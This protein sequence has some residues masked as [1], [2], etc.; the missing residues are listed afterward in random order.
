MKLGELVATCGAVREVRSRKQKTARLAVCLQAMDD[1]ERPVGACFLAGQLPAGRIG[2]GHAAVR[3]AHS[4]APA[5]EPTLEIAD[6]DRALGE[7]AALGGRGSASS[8]E[9]VLGA[10]FSRASAEEQSF[11]A[12]L[13]IGELRQGASEGVVIDAIAVAANVP[14]AAVRR[15][16]MLSGDLGEVARAALSGGSAALSA[17][18]LRLFRPVLPMLAQPIDDI[19]AALG[20]LGEASFELKLDGARIQLHKAEQ[21]IRVFSRGLNDVTHAVPELVEAALRWPASEIILD[22]EVIALRE[23]GTPYPFQETMRRFGR[24]LDVDALRG[25]RPLSP[26]YFDLLHLDGETLVD[27]PTRERI[28][29]LDELLPAP[30]RIPRAITADPERVEELWRSAL[31]RG[32]EGLMAKSLIAPY[33]AGGRGKSW[34]KLKPAHTLDLVVIAVEWGSG[35]RQGWLS[36]LHLGAR[37]PASGTFV[38][39]GKTFKGMTDAMLA[40][41]TERLLALEIARDEWTVYVRPEQVVEIAFNDVLASPHYPGGMALRF[42]RVRRY[43]EDKP[44]SEADTIDS[45]RAIFDASQRR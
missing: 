21:D 42:A 31:D 13:L 44:A 30:V 12:R 20:E 43:R 9:R 28:A 37:D 29:L 40:W 8:R 11:L 33:E 36:N 23:D 35:R 1:R 45:V 18:S 16:L 27:R 38:M 4:V 17:V 25:S 3:K 5:L 41:Q 15:A 32:H 24:R 7:L 22:G 6:V 39:L 34:F 10:L 26:F 19:D 14:P 2:V